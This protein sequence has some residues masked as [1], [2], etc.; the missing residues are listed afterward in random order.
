MHL[1]RVGVAALNQTPLD[2][3]GNQERLIKVLQ[4]AQKEEVQFLGLPE[5]ALCGYGCEDAFFSPSTCEKA[6]AS[7][8]ALLPY[9]KGLIVN[10]G[11][12]TQFRGALFNAIVIVADEQIVGILP[13]KFLAGDGVHY[14]PRWFKEWPSGFSEMVEWGEVTSSPVP[15]GDVCFQ[16]KNIRFGYE[17][18]EEAWVAQRPG[19]H[20]AKH[21]IDIL[22]NP[23]ASHFAFGKNEI[24]KRFVLEGSRAFSCVYAYSNLLGNEAGRLIYDGSLFI[25]SNGE[26]IHESQRLTYNDV[27]LISSA[28]DLNINRIKRNQ[29]SSFNPVEGLSSSGSDLNGVVKVVTINKASLE[30]KTKGE[31]LGNIESSQN[32]TFS[33][34]AKPKK[35][36]KPQILRQALTK[37]EE[38][39]HA[40]SLGLFDYL[41]KSRSKGFAISMSGG[42][43]SSVVAVLAVEALSQAIRELGIEKF[44]SQLS[45][46]SEIQP[47]KSRE[48]ILRSLVY[49]VYQSTQNSSTE[50]HHAAKTLAGA[51]GM[52]FYTW[53][54][55]SIKLEYET[56]ITEVLGRPLNWTTDD[57]PM[58]NIQARVRAPGI[59]LL[60]NIK[61]LLLLSTSNRSEAAV[62]Y[63]TMD[64]DLA[65]GLSPIAGVD[66]A[67]LN[68][69]IRWLS[70][71]G[72]ELK[73]TIPELQLA[74]QRPPTAELRPPQLHQS[75]EKD[76]MPYSLLDF[77]ERHLII[78]RLN[79]LDLL[80]VLI[81]EFPQYTQ[82]QLRD[83]LVRFLKLWTQNQWKRERMAP[84][85][86][87]DAQ[88]L[89]PKTWCRFPILSKA[90]ELDIEQ[91]LAI[92]K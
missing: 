20:L 45:H 44:K 30:F 16:W 81:L 3:R 53:S 35:I 38:F 32:K 28:I 68:Q 73:L 66:K 54:V 1:V 77:I 5:M 86:H 26:L 43:D 89:D 25:A 6:L 12:P 90:F 85:F 61:G 72:S 46:I 92:K 71:S 34:I 37:N 91:L 82:T 60:A 41:R 52:T 27:E 79:P 29:T 24:R 31:G 83:W 50:T 55:E 84:S 74:Y 15:I 64:G 11:M 58:Q 19:A 33:K 47:L 65:G 88:S 42:I 49:G 48:E 17:I 62:G 18:C 8:K 51:L 63:A 70:E 75:D 4:L 67:F 78:D 57:A 56:L 14:E 80:E 40:V 36:E 59:W 69:W 10:F 2:W 21:S 9:T 76:L 7:L 23:S 13:K 22:F 39:L 87:L